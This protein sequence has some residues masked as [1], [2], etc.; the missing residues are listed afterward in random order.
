MAYKQM[1]LLLRRYPHLTHV[2][3]AND[4][5]AFGVLRALNEAGR[6]PGKNVWLTSINT[7]E[8]VLRLRQ[9]GSI[10]VL[11]GGHFVAGA[12]GILLIDEHRHGSVLT[13]VSELSIFALIEPDSPLFNR[14]L[15]RQWQEIEFKRLKDQPE[16]WTH[17][18]AWL[19]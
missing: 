3:T 2:W 18:E 4:H 7:S 17:L 1:T 14:L 12:L 19:H 15:Q 9:Q 16:K 8:Q 6:T 10:S 11:G 13:S 5:M